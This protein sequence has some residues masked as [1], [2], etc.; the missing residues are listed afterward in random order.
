ME[1]PLSTK[2]ALLLALAWGEAYGLELMSRVSERTQN[3]V[4]LFEGSAYPALRQLERDKLIVPTRRV[5]SSAGRPRIY[6]RLTDEGARV[7]TR[8]RVILRQLTELAI[9]PDATAALADSEVSH[10]VAIERERCA[11]VLE[12]EARSKLVISDTW[13]QMTREERAVWRTQSEC[14]VWA[15]ELLRK[16][17]PLLSGSMDIFPVARDK[18]GRPRG[19]SGSRKRER[20][21]R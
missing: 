17:S 15:A 19:L 9:G 8:Y 3:G 18:N 4:N 6:Y 14:L 1:A 2:S 13:Q 21:T 10:A 7:A 5:R 11:K 16:S 12:E 20:V